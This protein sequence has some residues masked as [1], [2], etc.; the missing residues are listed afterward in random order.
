LD[1]AGHTETERMRRDHETYIQDFFDQLSKANPD[2]AMQEE[3]ENDGRPP[4][5]NV[6]KFPEPREPHS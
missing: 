6:L 1:E 2:T 4:A 5:S 3:P